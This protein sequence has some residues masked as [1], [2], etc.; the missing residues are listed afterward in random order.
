M[1]YLTQI[2]YKNEMYMDDFRRCTYRTKQTA[3]IFK[4]ACRDIVHEYVVECK[5]Y[6]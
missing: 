6:V 5:T 4:N 2:S 3:I 1:H